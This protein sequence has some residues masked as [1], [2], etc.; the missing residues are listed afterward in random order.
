[1]IVKYQTA[2]THPD[3]QMGVSK[4]L[5]FKKIVHLFSLSLQ[6]YLVLANSADPD[7]MLH[8]AAFHRVFTVC[9]SI[10]LGVSVS[11]RF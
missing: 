1:M 2:D 9:Q 6:T 11:Q 5:F 4:V 8:Y 10:H 3:P 7:E